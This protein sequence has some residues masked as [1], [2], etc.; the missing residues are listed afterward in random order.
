M[1]SPDKRPD[2][3]AGLRRRAEAAARE[4]AALSSETIGADSPE[5]DSPEASR[6]ILHELRVHQ[7]E[8]EMQNDELRRTQVKLDAARERYFDLYDLAPVGY[9][10][11]SEPGIIQEANLTAAKLLGVA[12]GSLV[13]QPIHRFILKEDQ[14]IFYLH[15]KKLFETGEPLAFE[16]RLVKKDRTSFWTRLEAT[17]AQEADGTALYRVVL[18]DISE[19]K[20]AEGEVRKLAERIS[21]IQKLEALGVLVAGVAHNMNNVLAAIMAAA[22]VRELNVSEPAD[23]E[24]YRTI[25]AACRRGR[26]V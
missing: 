8:L 13:N 19:R 26:E 14:D 22:S 5:P 6:K 11:I 4:R 9:C 24:T 15:R 21:Q 23:L 10:T 25:G 2:D 1:S 7:I 12:R 17:L 3:I 16:I 18:I 20:H